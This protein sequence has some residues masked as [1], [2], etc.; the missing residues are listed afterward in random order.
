MESDR[1]RPRGYLPRVTTDTYN[2]A[3][4]FGG[5]D[6]KDSEAVVCIADHRL[7]NEV[8]MHQKKTSKAT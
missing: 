5:V 4:R 7:A 6:T 2:L 1:I 8:V 3:Q